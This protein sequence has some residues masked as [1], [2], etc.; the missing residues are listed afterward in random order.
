MKKILPIISL[1]AITLSLSACD[2]QIRFDGDQIVAWA[3]GE[4]Y[5]DS[6]AF[7]SRT[8]AAS[9]G[10]VICRYSSDS[11][12]SVPL[13]NKPD[14]THNIKTS[15]DCSALANRPKGIYE[16]EGKLYFLEN[17]KDTENLNMIC[18]DINGGN[19]RRLAS[20]EYG[21]LSE[22]YERIRYKDGQV[23][24]TSRDTIDIDLL[25]KTY[26]VKYLDKYIATVRSIDLTSGEVRILAQRQDYEARISNFTVF[27]DTLI[28]F[29]SWFTAPSSGENG[30]RT[31]EE[32]AETYRYGVYA[33]D[34]KTGEEKCLT[35]GY[36]RMALAAPC[37]DYFSYDRLIFYST[38]TNELYKYDKTN[39]SF[40]PFAKCANINIWYMSDDKSALFLENE[41]DEYFCRY[42]F[43]TEEITRISREGFD[44]FWLNGT[45]TGEKAWFGYDDDNGEY[46]KG[47]MNR[48]DLMNGKYD[49]FTFAYYANEEA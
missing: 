1:L 30:R 27:E 40:T 28:Y 31:E 4:T 21:V 10:D 49:D 24:Y 36:E 39:G 13:C 41:E 34:L 6:G 44:L 5:S 22:V 25:E 17:D 2:S 43:E 38:D 19:R 11:A 12:L 16:A 14:C 29:Y 8:A 7:Y 20:V 46:C 45:I 18:A 9:G 48:D 32:F 15:P 35:E 33:A 42:D 23:F 3:G 26:E 37:F 47:Y